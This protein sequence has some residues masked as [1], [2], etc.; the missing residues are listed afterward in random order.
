MFAVPF[1]VHCSILFWIVFL[2]P[3]LR[4]AREMSVAGQSVSSFITLYALVARDPFEE[5]V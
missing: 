5:N 1:M 4:A 3:R 2:R